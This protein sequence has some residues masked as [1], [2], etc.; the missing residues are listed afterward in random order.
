M[1]SPPEPT[2]EVF[3]FPSTLR[4]QARHDLLDELSLNMWRAGCD[5]DAVG[6]A[7]A[8]LQA[9][10]G[11]FISYTFRTLA[12]KFITTDQGYIWQGP[13]ESMLYAKASFERRYPR[14]KGTDYLTCHE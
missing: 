2:Q 12:G 14:Y 3:T 5:L 9:Q 4:L 6:R 7:V 8:M 1:T 13:Q 11:Q 10:D